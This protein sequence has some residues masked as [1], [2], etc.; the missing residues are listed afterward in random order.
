MTKRK[1]TKQSWLTRLKSRPILYNLLLIATTLVALFVVAHLLLAVGTRH[2][3][4]RTVPQFKG[5]L[6]SDAER[7]ADREGLELVVN[8]SLYVAAFPGGV[9]LEQLP[10]GGVDV[11]SGRKIY[12]TINSFSQKRVAMP[13]VAGRSL[14]QAKNMLEVAGFGIDELVYVDDI[15]T[16]YVLS[17]HF[18][19]EEITPETELLVEKGRGVVL[20]VGV[21]GGSGVT[22]VPKLIGR[23]LFDAKSRLWEVGLN[24]GEVSYDE[25]ITMLNR[26]DARVYEQ[27]VL[28]TSE[29]ALGSRISI[30]LTLDAV[31]ISEGEIESE[32][33]L[34]EALEARML[35]DSLAAVEADS[36]RLI[37]EAK[38]AVVVPQQ[39]E[40]DN[41]F[42]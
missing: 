10:A 21:K 37:M 42:F 1:S 27:S 3:M 40:E 12:V 22:A 8:D 31:K 13:Y 5:L 28:Q 17:Q 9:V 25:G 2:G 38:E 24:V 33:R 11:K 30:R 32:R 18:E 15:A 26:G 6:L 7:V 16:N 39:S 14:R 4:K 34:R 19:G 23:Q 35:A 36:L 20:T 29:V 41:F